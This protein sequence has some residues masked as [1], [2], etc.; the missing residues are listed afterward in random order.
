MNFVVVEIAAI[1]LW[2]FLWMESIFGL[3][4]LWNLD[5][6][7]LLCLNFLSL[8]QYGALRYYNIR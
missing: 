4:R 1:I 5:T 6:G 8:Y 3:L 7:A 2:S